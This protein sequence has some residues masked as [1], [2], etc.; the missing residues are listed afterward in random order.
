MSYLTTPLC[1]LRYRLH[2]SGKLGTVSVVRDG[3]LLFSLRAGASACREEESACIEVQ[4]S[5]GTHI[6]SSRTQIS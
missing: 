6:G 1:A 4:S 5:L 3:A 2:V